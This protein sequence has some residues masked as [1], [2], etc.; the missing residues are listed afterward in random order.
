MHKLMGL[1]YLK[2]YLDKSTLHRTEEFPLTS[3]NY[4][5]AWNLLHD[6]YENKQYIIHCP[7]K[8]LVKLGP[9]I[10]PGV[11]DVREL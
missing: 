3:E 9:A 7:L 1:R 11:K 2:T 8:K 4:T 5:E 10:H 6:R